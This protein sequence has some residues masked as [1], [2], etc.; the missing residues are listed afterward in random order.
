LFVAAI[1]ATGCGGG[2]G[3]GG[4]SP[5]GVTAP[6]ASPPG[7]PPTTGGATPPD[8]QGTPAV[9]GVVGQQYSFQP[10]AKD[11]D[12]DAVT[13]TI[14]SKPEWAE[15]DASTGRLWGTPQMAH[16]GVHE[17]IEISV[18]DGRNVSSLPPFAVIISTAQTATTTVTLGWQAPTQNDDG[19][20]LTDL[21]GF[22]VYYGSAT[23]NYVG[24]IAIDNAGLTQHVVEDLPTGT[25]FFAITAI[26][27]EGLESVYSTEVTTTI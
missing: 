7:S 26:N 5:Q 13:F 18:T 1:I 20:P 10:T 21:T 4:G 27:A 3:G 14:K 22:R 16:V 24:T 17:N 12:G 6:P 15:F 8:I 25:Y 11:A 2:G 23:Q 19:T 9:A